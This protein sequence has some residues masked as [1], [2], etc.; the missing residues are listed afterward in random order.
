[1]ACQVSTSPSSTSPVETLRVACPSPPLSALFNI[2]IAKGYFLEEGLSVTAQTFESGKMALQAVLNGNADLAISTDFP[3]MMAIAAGQ[4]IAIVAQVGTV[5]NNLA[6]VARRDRGITEPADLAGKTIGVT[7]GT[8]ADYF[9]DSYLS[10][11]GITY[12]QVTRKNIN[13]GEMSAALREGMIDAV[14]VWN[15]YYRQLQEEW[16]DRGIVLTGA[17]CSTLLFFLSHAAAYPPFPRPFLSCWSVGLT[18]TASSYFPSIRS[19]P[20]LPISLP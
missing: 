5:G 17:C 3:V 18:R 7:F 13:P 1:M 6:I 2:T 16:A 19:S 8:S 4:P 14:S 11:Y 10:L 12:S 9:L 20:L 15:P